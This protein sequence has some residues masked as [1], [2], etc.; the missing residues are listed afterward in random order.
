MN[1]RQWPRLQGVRLTLCLIISSVCLYL[2]VRGMNFEDA[3]QQLKR[4]SPTP[5]LGAG[6]FLFLAF[7]IR[8]Y[9]WRY[10]LAPI[11][12]IPVLPL[13]RSTLIGFM[14]NYLLPF[15]AGEVMR[16]VSIGQTENISKW[17]AFGSIVL[18]RVFDGV[19]LS[20][21]PFFFL[22]VIDF[23]PWLTQVNVVLLA[24]YVAGLA[25]LGIAMQ[26][27]STEGWI[28][29]AIA[30]LPMHFAGRT[31]SVATKFLG[32]M[33]GITSS[34]ALLPIAVLSLVCW[35]F[36]GMYFFLM[37]MAL[38]LELSFAA[39]LVLQMVIG[40]GVVLP[41]APGYVG[42][43]EYFTVLGLA[44]FGITHEAAFAYALLA[45][46]FQFIPVT[47][48]GLF[49]ALRNGFQIEAETV[50]SRTSNVERAQN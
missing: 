46:I 22:A 27:G 19:V 36:H 45:H 49:F 10:L 14:G 5:V 50:S 31:G 12:T 47:V 18:E 30:L 3:L 2:A 33:K 32:G 34:R 43:F 38:D 4:S 28:Q 17:V 40:L 25:G 41:A 20:L 8:A 24:L 21:T 16:A 44:L 35:V 39:A 9:R 42:N 7:W 15:R 1:V 11:K 23:P 6:F 26:R 48:V 37:F 13:F 29:R